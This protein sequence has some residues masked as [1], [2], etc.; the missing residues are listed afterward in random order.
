MY[1][2]I[3]LIIIIWC[4]EILFK[5]FVFRCLWVFVGINHLAHYMD[6]QYSRLNVESLVTHIE[7]DNNNRQRILLLP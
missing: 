4:I 2:D 1:L 5:N 6:K 7:Q 3:I